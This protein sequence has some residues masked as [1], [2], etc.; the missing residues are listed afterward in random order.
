MA[1]EL[2]HHFAGDTRSGANQLFN[3]VADVWNDGPRLAIAAGLVGRVQPAPL[4]KF[5]IVR[6]HEFYEGARRFA[7]PPGAR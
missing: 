3:A 5:G 7:R 2:S 6:N 4:A 1:H